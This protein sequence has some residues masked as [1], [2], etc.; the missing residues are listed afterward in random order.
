MSFLDK[1]TRLA[2]SLIPELEPFDPSVFND[3]IANQTAWTPLVPGGSSFRTHRIID[4]PP[5]GL[6]MTKTIWTYLFGLVF[7]VVG[8][9]VAIGGAL[10]QKW[11]AVPFGAVFAI[12]GAAIGWPK[13]ILFDG[14]ARQ[15]RGNGQTVPFSQIY[16]LQ[17]V[18]EYIRGD[19]QSYWSYELNLVLQEGQRISVVDHGNLQTLLDDARRIRDLLGCKLWDAASPTG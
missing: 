18:K 13:T 3:P 2:K 19:K 8:A 14:D 4:H 16:A 11:I 7:F 9:G 15:F 17:V 5:N 12:G 6:E 10:N 1:V